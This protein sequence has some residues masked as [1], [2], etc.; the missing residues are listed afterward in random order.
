MPLSREADLG[1]GHIVLDGKWAHSSPSQKWRHSP[2]SAHVCCGQTGGWTKIP[3]GTEVDPALP[4]PAMGHTAPI[5]GPCLLWPNAW[6]DQNATRYKL[7][8]V[9]N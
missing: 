1:P 6:T 2:F 5:F 7:A 4:P 3:L 8:T 9:V